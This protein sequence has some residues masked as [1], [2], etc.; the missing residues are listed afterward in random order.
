MARIRFVDAAKDFRKVADDYSNH[1]LAP[2]ALLRAGDA[3]V[4]QWNR[5]ELDPTSGE[6]AVA[7]YQELTTRYPSSHAAERSICPATRAGRGR[8]PTRV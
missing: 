1:P 5:V 7:S 4:A 3:A 2:D 8:R 6:E